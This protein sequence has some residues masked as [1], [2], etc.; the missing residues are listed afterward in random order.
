MKRSGRYILEFGLIAAVMLIMVLGFWDIYFG[1]DAA[2][3]P[4]HHLHLATAFIWI[5]LLLAQLI[6]IARGRYPEHRKVG[7]AVLVAAPLL[8]ATTAMLSVHSAH[9]G[10]VSGKE[11]S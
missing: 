4:Y 9:K 10:M 1:A 7:L 5:G 2:A 8:V 6:L 3:Q 11:T